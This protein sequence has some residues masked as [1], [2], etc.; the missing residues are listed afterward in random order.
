[1]KYQIESNVV[2][3]ADNR[4]ESGIRHRKAVWE[5]SVT[6]A[7]I[8]PI[9][10]PIPFIVSGK[11]CFGYAIVKEFTVTAET[12]SIKFVHTPIDDKEVTNT[13]YNLYRNGITANGSDDYEDESDVII[14]GMGT[15]GSSNF[16]KPRPRSGSWSSDSDN[17]RPLS[18]YFND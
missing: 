7:R 15:K 6:G 14:P 3:P 18:S 10:T 9:D 5:V 16:G 4:T 17:R 2:V 8:Y 12:T 13:L 11:G 1:M